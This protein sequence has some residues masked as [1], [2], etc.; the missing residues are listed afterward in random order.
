VTG[1]TLESELKFG[2]DGEAPLISLAAA[3]TLGPATLGPARTVEELDRYLDTASLRLAAR[4]WACRLRTRDGHTVISLKGPAEHMPGA[5]LHE[6]RE[7][8]GP[9]TT[10]ISAARWPASEARDRVVEMTGDEP[11]VERLALAQQR[12]ERAVLHNGTPTG[13]LSLDRVRVLK[14]GREIGQLRLVELEFDRTAAA[15]GVDPGPLAA[16][17]EQI[18]GLRADPLTK[19]EHALEMASER[20]R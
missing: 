20:P 6:R 4:R 13:I 9:A 14:D 7:I 10:E 16:A 1:S 3:T 17:L 19:L 18:E 12:T 2:A 8:E 5:T 11:L 15:E